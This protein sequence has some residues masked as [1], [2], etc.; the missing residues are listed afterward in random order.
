[1]S[2]YNDAGAECPK[3]GH[4]DRDAWEWE[5]GNEACGEYEC[6]KCGHEFM[7]SRTLSVTYKSWDKGEA[8]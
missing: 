8:S 1:M 4:V 7:V 2:A 6:P 3:C 5:N